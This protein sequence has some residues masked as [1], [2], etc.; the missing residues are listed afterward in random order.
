VGKNRKTEKTEKKIIKKLN[1]EKN[2]IKSI[3]ILKK[4]AGLVSVL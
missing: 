1:P 2:P 4:P 3:K